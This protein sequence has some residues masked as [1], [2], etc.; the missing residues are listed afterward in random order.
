MISARNF[1]ISIQNR[2]HGFLLFNYNKVII[3]D[4]GIAPISCVMWI[5]R[6]FVWADN[7][8]ETSAGQ[9]NKL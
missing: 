6:S 1:D 3:I 2:K 8:T 7:L 4:S 9:E 5:L